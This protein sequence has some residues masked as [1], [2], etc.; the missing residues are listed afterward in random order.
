MP[1]RAVEPVGS[2]LLHGATDA[3]VE[4]RLRGTI[5]R[6]SAKALLRRLRMD[7]NNQRRFPLPARGEKPAAKREQ[8]NLWKLRS[9]DHGRVL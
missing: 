3:V 9:I 2:I 8:S 4:V 6:Q 5:D 7:V 1:E